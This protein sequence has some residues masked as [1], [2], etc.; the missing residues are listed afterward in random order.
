[1]TGKSRLHGCPCGNC[2]I[3]FRHGWKNTGSKMHISLCQSNQI[4]ARAITNKLE[5]GV[6]YQEGLSGALLW[7][8]SS[9]T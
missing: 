2:G 5:Q 1:M 6:L 3:M 4:A 9:T 8:L 7:I